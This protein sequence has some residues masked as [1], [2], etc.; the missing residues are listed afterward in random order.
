MN[1][2][3]ECDVCGGK[4]W[5]HMG[6]PFEVQRCDQCTE[7]DD[8]VA[9]D[10]HRK[11]C[12]CDWPEVDYQNLAFRYISIPK[13]LPQDL[14]TVLERFKATVAHRELFSLNIN[15]L[16]SILG[17]ALELY[18]K[19]WDEVGGREATLYQHIQGT[20]CLLVSVSSIIQRGLW[21]PHW[22]WGPDDG[23][24]IDGK[25]YAQRSARESPS[26]VCESIFDRVLCAHAPRLEAALAASKKLRPELDYKRLY[27]LLSWAES[28]RDEQRAHSLKNNLDEAKRHLLEIYPDADIPKEGT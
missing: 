19:H 24:I 5:I 6:E 15:R 27:K 9:V 8:S 25:W 18:Y 11:D 26:D 13:G 16:I 28:A 4:K 10:L 1:D 22:T 7:D 14:A 20:A 17:E 3:E 2:D 23:T 21:K 12:G